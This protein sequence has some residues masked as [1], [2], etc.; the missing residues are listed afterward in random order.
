[1]TFVAKK[2]FL[3]DI[4]QSQVVPGPN[5]YNWQQLN[6]KLSYNSNSSNSR[7]LMSL[8]TCQKVT[9]P[10]RCMGKQRHQEDGNIFCCL[11]SDCTKDNIFYSFVIAD[12]CQMANYWIPWVFPWRPESK[13][14]RHRSE[15]ITYGKIHPKWLDII[16]TQQIIQAVPS[17]THLTHRK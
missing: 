16:L 14:A 11:M 3:T 9:R 2:Y 17:G 10:E 8:T 7:D 13:P 1:M 6:S 5:T 4:L 15:H 12:T